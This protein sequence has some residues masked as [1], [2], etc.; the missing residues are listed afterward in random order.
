MPTLRILL[1]GS[2]A[3][4]APGTTPEKFTPIDGSRFL[5]LTHAGL[6]RVM[7]EPVEAAADLVGRQ[8]LR[9]IPFELSGYAVLSTRRAPGLRS[10]MEIPV[11]GKASLVCLAQFCDADENETPPPGADRIEKVGQ[12]LADVVMVYEDGTEHRHPIRRR[13]EVSSQS[14]PWGHLCFAA[15][16]HRQD[17]A[18]TLADAPAAAR[19]WNSSLSESC[20]SGRLYG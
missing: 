8:T 1:G 14:V 3:A 2:A 16:P 19:R 15:V 9:G 13:F 12:H 11:H 18:T 20:W 6:K 4:L 17:V 5:T 7:R 10:R